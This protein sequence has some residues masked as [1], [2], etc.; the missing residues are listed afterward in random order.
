MLTLPSVFLKKSENVFAIQSIPNALEVIHQITNVTLARMTREEM[1]PAILDQ[2]IRAL[3]ADSASL[4]FYHPTTQRCRVDMGCGDW[5]STSGQVFE[6]GKSI[7]DLIIKNGKTYINVDM[8]KDRRWA[9]QSPLNRPHSV[10]GVPLKTSEETIGVLWIGRRCHPGHEIIPF[11]PDE[12]QLLEV[13]GRIV[14]NS[15]QRAS[16]QEKAEKRSREILALN[17]IDRAINSSYDLDYSL[18]TVLDQIM[19][20]LAVDAADILLMDPKTLTIERVITRG[21]IRANDSLENDILVQQTFVRQA[22]LEKKLVHIP[23]FS[24]VKELSSNSFWVEKEGFVTALAVPLIAKN[25]IIAV[26]CLF[27]R[28]ILNPSAEWFRFL[29]AITAQ[30]AVAISSAMTF[31]RMQRSNNELIQ[32]YDAIL[33]GWV[34]ILEL[35]D[36]ETEHHTRRVTE[37]TVHLAH[38]LG[39]ADTE[40]IHIRRGALL[41]DIG[42]IGI[43]DQI[44]KKP[45]PL[46][47]PEWE[48][49]RE[50]PV[51]AY[52]MLSAIPYLRQALDIP[53]YHH[54]RWD[55]SG[56]PNK[57]SGEQIPLAARLFSIVD[58]YDALLSDRPYRQ[59]WPEEKVLQYIKDQ[60][61]S[62]FDPCL[63]ELF[64]NTYSNVIR[65]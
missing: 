43:P 60:A 3:Q 9:A 37:M 27:H 5:E 13:I 30:A 35:R 16:L 11:R 50:H 36:I 17:A 58:V 12:V 38:I 41:H 2:L 44:L 34:N 23:D 1:L 21:Y 53:Y 55:G 51:Y 6:P 48:I 29:E 56:Y 57:L 24:Q 22:V 10:V 33:Q 14:A 15:I 26:L 64:I 47:D 8:T 59:A 20:H 62:H 19:D 42:K 31:D 4:V 65:P 25:Q 54:E 63:V 45:G 49:M 52:E 46:S 39:I 32:S 28:S 18:N 7:S 61:G 40:I